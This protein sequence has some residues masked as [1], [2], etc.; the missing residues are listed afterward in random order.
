MCTRDWISI[1]PTT[2]VGAILF[3]VVFNHFGITDHVSTMQISTSTI[4]TE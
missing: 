3:D 4:G 1:R 2:D